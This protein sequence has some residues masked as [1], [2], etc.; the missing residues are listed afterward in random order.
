MAGKELQ[1]ALGWASDFVCNYSL[2][3]PQHTMLKMSCLFLSLLVIMNGCTK[4]PSFSS[5]FLERWNKHGA[6]FQAELCHLTLWLWL[7]YSSVFSRQME[8]QP[9][10]Y[11]K[12]LNR[13]V[14]EK[15]QDLHLAS[16][17]PRR[18]NQVISVWN[19][20]PEKWCPFQPAPGSADITHG[21]HGHFLEDTQGSLC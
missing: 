14:M 7:L 13:R 11:Y 10:F 15:P 8:P 2:P 1:L 9:V 3:P 16:W 18:A 5:Y 19:I 12:A 17:R 4:S 21:S 20:K 6:R